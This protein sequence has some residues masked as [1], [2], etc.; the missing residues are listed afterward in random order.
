MNSSI[1]DALRLRGVNFLPAPSGGVGCGR[2]GPLQG[3]GTP[4][5]CW[6][7]LR[8]RASAA[9]VLTVGDCARAQ[10]H[11]GCARSWPGGRASRARKVDHFSGKLGNCRDSRNSGDRPENGLRRSAVRAYLG[12]DGTG[13]ASEFRAAR[14]FRGLATFENSDSAHNA[15]RARMEHWA[16]GFGHFGNLRPPRGISF[17]GGD[18]LCGRTSS[19]VR[20]GV[21]AG[22][23]SGS[24]RVRLSVVVLGV[25]ARRPSYAPR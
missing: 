20:V 11:V 12:S 21:H 3:H 2:A 14:G 17:R 19:G 4:R 25:A 7:S 6:R 1:V 23:A 15:D 24:F 13:G 5:R 9:V 16:S 10:K 22:A 18:V 8:R